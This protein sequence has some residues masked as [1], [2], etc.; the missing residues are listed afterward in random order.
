[1]RTDKYGLYEGGGISEVM[2]GYDYDDYLDV[3]ADMEYRPPS[4]YDRC[5]AKC[6]A[7]RTLICQPFSVAG[8][9]CGVTVAGIASIPSGGATFPGF[10]RVG[11]AVGGWVRHR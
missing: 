1:M 7:K 3:I 10:A 2:P 4:P 9:S 8:S 11:T 5:V 6:V